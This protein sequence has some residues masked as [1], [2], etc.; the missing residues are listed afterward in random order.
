MP[1][2]DFPNRYHST[3]MPCH[4]ELR[5]STGNQNEKQSPHVGVQWLRVLS[6]GGSRGHIVRLILC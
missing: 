1:C 6:V 2:L 4:E 3:T 5:L